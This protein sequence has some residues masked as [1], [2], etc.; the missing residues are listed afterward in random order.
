MGVGHRAVC[1]VRRHDDSLGLR[2]RA[3]MDAVGLWGGGLLAVA[4]LVRVVCHPRQEGK[5]HRKM[6]KFVAMIAGIPFAILGAALKHPAFVPKTFAW[7]AFAA[8]AFTIRLWMG[9]S[10]SH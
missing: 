4:W 8:Q 3:P 5:E 10:S 6:H 2:R 9:T 7:A 1:W